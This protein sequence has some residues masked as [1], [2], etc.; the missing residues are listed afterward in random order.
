MRDVAAL[1]GEIAG[2]AVGLRDTEAFDGSL[3]PLPSQVPNAR[4][5]SWYIHFPKASQ[6]GAVWTERICRYPGTSGRRSYPK[7]PHTDT[8]SALFLQVSNGVHE[9]GI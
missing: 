4:T 5:Y 9:K 8:Q 3:L 2:V 6:N 1:L 7:H